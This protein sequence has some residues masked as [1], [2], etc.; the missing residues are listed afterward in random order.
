M[1]V[2]LSS[3]RN[4]MEGIMMS[5]A[6]GPLA[7]DGCSRI[8]LLVQIDLVGDPSE[9]NS[10]LQLLA[11]PGIYAPTRRPFN[12]GNLNLERSGAAYRQTTHL[13]GTGGMSCQRPAA[14]RDICLRGDARTPTTTSLRVVTGTLK[15]RIPGPST[16]QTRRIETMRFGLHGEKKEH[17][18][19]TGFEKTFGIRYMPLR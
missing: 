1:R 19:E 7:R 4:I 3:H 2:G 14:L 17:T 18:R 16:I 15:A 8:S 11:H 5:L 9:R 13:S 6:E 10:S 12:R